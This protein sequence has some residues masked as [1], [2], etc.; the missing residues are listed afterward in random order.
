MFNIECLDHVALLVTDLE[1]S[2]E[3]Y[4]RVL[5][6]K[7]HY[8]E[9]WDI[10]VVLYA[11]TTGI[12]LFP[13]TSKEQKLPAIPRHAIVMQHFAFR[14]SRS[15]FEEA[16]RDFQHR[17]IKYEI[18]DH[19]VAHSIYIYDPDGYEVELTTYDI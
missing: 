3:W 7:R 4:T 18:Q 11:G 1:R 19:D 13:A 2:V 15:D 5:G 14:V 12:A 17:E 16:R 8:A 10:P 6:L 9:A